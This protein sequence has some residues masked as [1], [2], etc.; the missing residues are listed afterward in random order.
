LRYYKRSSYCELL[1][2]NCFL[3]IVWFFFCNCYMYLISHEPSIP[4]Y[5]G[6]SVILNS[7]NLVLIVG[8]S[9]KFPSI[10]RAT[11]VETIVVLHLISNVLGC[12]YPTLFFFI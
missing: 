1:K 8:Y 3:L 2:L 11:F 10:F 6:D 4:F 9:A 7:K 12:G 5:P